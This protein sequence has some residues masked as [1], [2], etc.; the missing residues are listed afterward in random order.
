MNMGD[1]MSSTLSNV[2]I[3]VVFSTK[4]RLELITPDV[5]RKLYPYIGGIIGGEKGECLGIGGTSDHIHILIK[6]PTSCSVADMLQRVKGS[7]SHWI[8]EQPW[9]PL[10]FAWQRGYAAFSVS[11]SMAPKVKGYI[12]SQE[13]HHRGTS[14]KEEL[15]SL[16][17]KHTV[18]YDEKY[19]WS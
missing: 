2:L 19:L 9:R 13:E 6:I 7:S 18:D 10:L 3:H 11:K 14:F 8:A 16:L 4:N 15:V 17:K 5:R 1:V 12:E